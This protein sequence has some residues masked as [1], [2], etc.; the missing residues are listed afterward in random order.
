ME[1]ELEHD[2]RITPEML[3]VCACPVDWN[4]QL[5]MERNFTSALGA[6][7]GDWVKRIAET[8]VSHQEAEVVAWAIIDHWSD[9]SDDELPQLIANIRLRRDA[10]VA[11]YMKKVGRLAGIKFLRPSEHGK[12]Y[13]VK[14]RNTRSADAPSI[15][16]RDLESETIAT[17]FWQWFDDM[18]LLD[19]DSREPWHLPDGQT[20]L[21]PVAA[22][23]NR[24]EEDHQLRIAL[25][26]AAPI[27]ERAGE[28]LR[29][30]VIDIHIDTRTAHAYPVSESEA[31]SIMGALP[32]RVI[33]SR[34]YR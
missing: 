31:Q 24:F 7:K 1:D 18:F 33:K 17:T 6:L 27:G 23:W 15:F 20:F 32:V 14:V 10:A 30:V 22:L 4:S 25:D 12:H 13:S 34:E 9:P 26:T 8:G 3:E 2:P 28:S 5:G 21:R 11:V 29:H 16:F 19:P